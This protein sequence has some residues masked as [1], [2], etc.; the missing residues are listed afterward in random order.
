MKLFWF[1]LAV[2]QAVIGGLALLRF[3]DRM[4]T[5]GGTFAFV[6]L[7]VGILFLFGAWKAMNR[8]RARR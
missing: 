2:V 8:A 4:K 6:F 5:G 3:G 1:L 7:V